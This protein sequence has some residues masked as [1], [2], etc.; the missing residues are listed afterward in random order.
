MNT[1][2]WASRSPGAKATKFETIEDVNARKAVPPFL[3]TLEDG[4]QVESF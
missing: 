3:V 2:G 1:A 4:S